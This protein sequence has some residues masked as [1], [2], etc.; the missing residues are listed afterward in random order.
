[1]QYIWSISSLAVKILFKLDTWI[2]V[3]RSYGI[4]RIIFWFDPFAE[5]SDIIK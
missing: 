4:N 5:G 2:Y 1:M 3:P